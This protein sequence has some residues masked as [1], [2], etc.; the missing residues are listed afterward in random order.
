MRIFDRQANED[1]FFR[2]FVC[3]LLIITHGPSERIEW[4][5]ILLVEYVARTPAS[6]ATISM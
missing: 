3:S 6:N 1:F 4:T 2:L 5:R